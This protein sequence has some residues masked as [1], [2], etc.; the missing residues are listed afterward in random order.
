VVQGAEQQGGVDADV[1]PVQLSGVTDGGAGQR[2]GWLLG[3]GAQGLLDV[4]RQRV[5]QMDL[6]ALGGQGQGIDP[7]GP[8]DVQH[9]RG[10]GWQVAAE[11]LP[12]PHVLRAPASEPLL[13]GHA[14]VVGGDLRVELLVIAHPG[15]PP[16]GHTTVAGRTWAGS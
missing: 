10:W 2:G 1:G 16:V 8:A 6:V 15:A 5:D 7:G 13:L 11:Q 12:G 14:G 3:R 4:Q 9:D